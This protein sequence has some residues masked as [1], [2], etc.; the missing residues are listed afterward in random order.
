MYGIRNM[1]TEDALLITEKDGEIDFTLVDLFS[2]ILAEA[3]TEIPMIGGYQNKVN[4]DYLKKYLKYK[5][6]YIE[7]KNATKSTLKN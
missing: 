3:R 1:A 6:K 4:N 7:L 2:E 5:S